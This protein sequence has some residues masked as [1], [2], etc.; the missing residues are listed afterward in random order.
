MS[1]RDN[2]DIWTA[3]TI[4]AIVGIGTALIVRARQEDD[5]HEVVRRVRRMRP[6]AEKTLKRARRNVSRRADQASDAGE[7]LIQAGREAIEELRR[8]A[9]GIVRRTRRELQKAASKTAAAVRDVD[10]AD[11]A[12]TQKQRIQ[13]AW[14]K[15]R[16]ALS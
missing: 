13:R 7:E 10:P 15:T 12:D 16:G 3:V 6:K 14:K 5:V 9:A 8:E 11:V 1:D 2:T 4:G